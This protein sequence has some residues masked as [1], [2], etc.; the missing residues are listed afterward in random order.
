ML[1][2]ELGITKG[3]L[4]LPEMNGPPNGPEVFRV[5]AMRQG[6]TGMNRN[7]EATPT[8]MLPL[9]PTIEEL[10][11]SLTVIV[12]PPTVTS[13]A[14]NVPT[15]L[16]NVISAGKAAEGSALVKCTGSV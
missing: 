3:R 14:V 7:P 9:V 15:P 11:R 12:C 8:V 13:E 6:V 2:V 5:S 16:V 10:N 4:V 1:H